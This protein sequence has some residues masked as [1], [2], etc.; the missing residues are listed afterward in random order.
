MDEAKL[1]KLSST[2]VQISPEEKAAVDAAYTAN[3][4]QYRKRKRIVCFYLDDVLE[5]HHAPRQRTCWMASW[6][7]IPRVASS[8]VCVGSALGRLAF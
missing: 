3:L 1:D 5:V 8:F 7:T 6:K 2:E 4:A